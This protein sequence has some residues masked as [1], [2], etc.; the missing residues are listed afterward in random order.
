MK[1]Q[2]AP[3]QTKTERQARTFRILASAESEEQ[4]P[5]RIELLKVG[6]WS[7]PNHGDF[8]VTVADLHEYKRN[9]DA[10]IA[11]AG[12]SGIT[13]DYDHKTGVAGG[14][15]KGLVVGV[16][17]N[18]VDTLFADPVEW[19][20][21]GK[22]DLLEKN[23]KCI[24]PEF[25]PASRG[26]WPDPEAEG[27]YIPNVLAAAALVNRPL[28]KGLTPILAS[29]DTQQ[30]AEDKNII[31]V[32]ASEK[33][34]QPM[35]LADIRVKNAEELSEDEKSFLTEHQTELT[36]DEQKKFGLE[37]SET[38][39]QKAEREAAEAKA[40]EEADAKA[41]AEAE[42]K[43]VEE[44]ANAG[45]DLT[46]VQPVMA[47]AVK[48]DEGRVVLAASEVRELVETKQKFE[49]AEAEN[50]VKTH[51]ERGAIK[52]DQLNATVDMILN[53]DGAIR[54]GFKQTIENLPS[55]AATGKTA[56][57]SNGVGATSAVNAL[58]EKANAAIKAAADNG[59]TLS[60]DQAV[61][62]VRAENPELAK[63]YDEESKGNI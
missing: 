30:S 60:F 33:E 61:S 15:I 45:I 25:Y 36:A 40:K 2:T 18:G 42:R 6:L 31:Y 62:A 35:N 19:S 44:Q 22:R 46:N 57:G 52:A 28:F 55:N 63:A 27:S 20:G 34:Q 54:A 50:F 13:I 1:P 3:T 49:R 32:S 59:N 38:A 8:V 9:F 26:G 53:T 5:N 12:A 47:S 58:I 41:K 48:G 10:G 7:T 24:S 37:V 56:G 14:W 11:Q 39:E 4:L 23:Y 16:D 51:I 43:E 29:A 17:A 21:Q